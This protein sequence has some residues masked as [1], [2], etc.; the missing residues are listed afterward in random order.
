MKQPSEGFYMGIRKMNKNGQMMYV[1]NTYG[2]LR[3]AFILSA[4]FVGCIVI[5]EA[6]SKE[7]K[8]LIDAV[9]ARYNDHKK[10]KKL[11]SK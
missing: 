6:A 2:L 11:E 5:T 8:R 9:K 1:E 10:K 4:Y 7:R 3:T